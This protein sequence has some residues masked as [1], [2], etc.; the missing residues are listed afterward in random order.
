MFSVNTFTQPTEQQEPVFPVA[1]VRAFLRQIST[2]FMLQHSHRD[3]GFLPHGC[4]MTPLLL[5]LHQ[6]DVTLLQVGLLITDLF[7][8]NAAPLDTLH[9]TAVK[10]GTA[11]H[12]RS[13][14]TI[15]GPR[16][17]TSSLY[18]PAPIVKRMDSP[19]LL[20]DPTARHLHVAAR[21][22]PGLR[23]PH[24][25]GACPRSIAKAK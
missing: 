15:I 6:I 12:A 8:P 22:C 13:H 21:H 4:I 5:T 2:G 18:L 25:P 24:V 11:V 16:S 7:V 14:R 1:A 20:L 9:D 3:V 23:L 10:S 19:P 17:V